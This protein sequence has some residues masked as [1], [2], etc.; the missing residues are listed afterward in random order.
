MRIIQV[1][2]GGD[3]DQSDCNRR[4]LKK[5]EEEVV[6]FWVCCKY[7]IHLITKVSPG[8]WHSREVAFAMNRAVDNTQHVGNYT[9]FRGF[10]YS[11]E[12][13]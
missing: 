3:W 10:P 6:R 11:K 12:V 7:W 4:C 5:K 9:A 1:G 8:K 13:P 2:N